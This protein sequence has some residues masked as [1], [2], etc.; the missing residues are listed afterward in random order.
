MKIIAM[1]FL[2]TMLVGGSGFAKGGR[3]HSSKHH[4]RASKKT[5]GGCCSANVSDERVNGYVKKDGTH[6]DEYLRTAPNG[7]QNDNF[8]T[9]A[10]INPYTG[11]DGY[12]EPKK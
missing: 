5:S 2:S 6:V 9:K 10:N 12:K 8:S 11:K 4:S 3:S 1:L 7:T